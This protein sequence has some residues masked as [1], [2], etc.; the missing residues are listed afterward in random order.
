MNTESLLAKTE[1]FIESA[2]VLVTIGDLDSAASRLYYAMFY[3]ASIL[4]DRLGYAYSSHQAVVAAYGKY[5]AKT[6]ELDPRFHRILISAFEMRQLGDYSAPSG[7]TQEQ[8]TILAQ[9]ATAF[10]TATRHWLATHP[11]TVA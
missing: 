9:E 8:I 6:Q 4:L 5:F 11:P 10:L 3:M 1:Q 2:K 7:I